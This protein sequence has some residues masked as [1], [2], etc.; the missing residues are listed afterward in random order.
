MFSESS[1]ENMALQL[2]NMDIGITLMRGGILKLVNIQP[3]NAPSPMLSM[4]SL[5]RIVV[6]RECEKAASQI[7]LNEMG[8]FIFVIEWQQCAK[9]HAPISTRPSHSSTSANFLRALNALAGTDVT[10]GST[11][12]RTTSRGASN[13][14]SPV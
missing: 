10:E 2:D 8:M 4:P 14:P 13:P 3:A 11:R 12:T 7:L 1:I 5:R 9:D 6:R